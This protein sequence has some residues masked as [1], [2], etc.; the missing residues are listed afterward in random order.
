MCV[1][2]IGPY[3]GRVPSATA[4]GCGGGGSAIT[5]DA[6]LGLRQRRQLGVE[7]AQGRLK[8][9]EWDGEG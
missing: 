2:D 9:R 5:Y 4:A 8:P 3:P 7:G 1:R 6:E